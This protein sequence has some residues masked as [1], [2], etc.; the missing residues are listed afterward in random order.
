[1]L[2]KLDSFF[3]Q[4]LH[5]GDGSSKEQEETEPGQNDNIAKTNRRKRR[6]NEEDKSLIETEEDA[7]DSSTNSDKEPNEIIFLPE[8]YE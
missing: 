3:Q 1:M 2:W 5:A 4:P 8:D 7:P 6:H